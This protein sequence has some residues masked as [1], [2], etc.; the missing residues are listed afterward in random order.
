M[1]YIIE[2][3]FGQPLKHWLLA[4]P[5]FFCIQSKI[6]E[7]KVCCWQGF[8]EAYKRKH[9]V[10]AQRLTSAHPLSLLFLSKA[11]ISFKL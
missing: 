10:T 3:K 9:D 1:T 11:S 4:Q 7:S 6:I 5:W 2:S 8:S